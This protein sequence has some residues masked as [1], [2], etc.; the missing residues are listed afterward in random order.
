[1]VQTHNLET[2]VIGLHL[3]CGQPN[4]KRQTRMDGGVVG[5]IPRA[6]CLSFFVRIK[7][8]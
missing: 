6:F 4:E 7:G 1:M 2:C 8:V 3:Q 5:S